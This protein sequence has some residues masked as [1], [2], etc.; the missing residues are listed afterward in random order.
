[1]RRQVPRGEDLYR[2]RRQ[3]PA[4]GNPDQQ[5]H[6]GPGPWVLGPPSRREDEPELGDET[7]INNQ[8]VANLRR[9]YPYVEHEL[10]QYYVWVAPNGGSETKVKNPGDGHVQ[11]SEDVTA[12]PGHG[13]F[14]AFQFHRHHSTTR[15]LRSPEAMAQAGRLLAS[16]S[17]GEGGDPT[18]SLHRTL[19]G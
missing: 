3:N 16:Q 17:A 13:C 19:H 11:M 6:L 8:I 12:L 1:M 7:S 15:D 2:C 9:E 5:D 18:V 4:T 10:Q 14:T